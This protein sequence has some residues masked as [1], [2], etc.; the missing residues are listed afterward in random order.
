M[1]RLS[2]VLFLLL[3]AAPTLGQSLTHPASDDTQRPVIRMVQSLYQHV[4]SRH[5]LG[6]P[7]AQNRKIFEPYLGKSLLRQIAQAKSCQGDW[8]RQTRGQVVKEPFAW[9]ETGFFSGDEELSEPS[10][11]QVERTESDQDGSFLVHVKLTKSPPDE[12]P[13]SWDVVVKVILEEKRPVVDDVVYLKGD[14]VTAE[15]RLSQILSGGCNGSHWNGGNKQ[16][17]RSN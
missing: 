1:N 2:Y 6:I 7:T 9:G 11:F 17:S 12:K 16:E 4:I 3:I 5:P 15:Y 14:G 8:V 10:S 13:W